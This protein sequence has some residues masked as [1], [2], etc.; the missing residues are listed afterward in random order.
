MDV[1]TKVEAVRVGVG[2]SLV[3][4]WGMTMSEVAAV[5]TALYMLIQIIILAPRAC[6]VLGGLFKRK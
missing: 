1:N 3:T 5:A 2:A 4:I 6:E